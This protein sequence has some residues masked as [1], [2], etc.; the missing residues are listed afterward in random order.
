M[1][2]GRETR[3]GIEVMILAG[4]G[5]LTTRTDIAVRLVEAG[6]SYTHAVVRLFYHAVAHDTPLVLSVV[7]IV[8]LLGEMFS[9]TSFSVPLADAAFVRVM[10]MLSYGPRDFFRP[11]FV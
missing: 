5:D 9:M 3:D 2:E 4:D 8:P 6:E 11:G 10:P 7:D 1:I